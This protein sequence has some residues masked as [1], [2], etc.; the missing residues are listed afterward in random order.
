MY[1]VLWDIVYLILKD[2]EQKPYGN[3]KGLHKLPTPYFSESVIHN[4][5]WGKIIFLKK[6]L[7]LSAQN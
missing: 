6:Y 3:Q 1:D 4:R 5:L 7:R 2:I